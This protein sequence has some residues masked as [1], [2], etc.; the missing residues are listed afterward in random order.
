MSSRW[1]ASRLKLFERYTLATVR[2][3][4]RHP[5]LWLVFCDRRSPGWFR[6]ELEAMLTEPHFEAVWLDE[7]FG[8]DICAREVAQRASG[9]T[10]LITTRLDNDDL[11]A[12]DFI[13]AIQACFNEQVLGFVNFTHGA[14]TED[15]RIYLRSDPSNAFVSLIE[16]RTPGRPMTVFVDAHNRLGKHGKI[17][18][19]RTH[20]M[21]I[22]V[23]HGANMA[24]LVHGIRT[25]PDI[26][27]RYFDAR[28]PVDHTGVVTLE[29][30]RVISA[31][32][33][34]VRVLSRPHRIRWGWHVLFFGCSNSRSSDRAGCDAPSVAPRCSLAR[35]AAPHGHPD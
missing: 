29:V 19:V 2:S 8:R 35:R 3:Q 15:G 23:I 11:V 17:V 5:D 21:W 22:Q 30:D 31:L 25:R 9:C 1:L 27:L 13:D 24:N 7:V 4:V 14:Q 10:F 26:V 20:P 18:Q 12:R 6:T 16:R 28:L 33:L 34:A 32:R